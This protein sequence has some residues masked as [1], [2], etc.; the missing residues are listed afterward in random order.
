MKN[1]KKISRANLK[2][3]VGGMAPVCCSFY[4][5]HLQRCCATPS[6]M[7]CPPA[8]VDDAFPC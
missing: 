3:V 1:L 2:S 7:S 8:W 6:S 4:P 5:P